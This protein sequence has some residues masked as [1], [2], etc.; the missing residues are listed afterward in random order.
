M[1]IGVDLRQ[2]SVG[3]SGGITQ[4]VQG[5][6]GA[7]FNQYSEHQFLIFCTPFNRSLLTCNA[8]NVRYFSLSIASYFQDLDRIAAE[9]HLQVLFRSYPTEDTL[10]FPMDKQIVLIPDNQHET[11]PD[12]FAAEVLRADEAP[13]QGPSKC[14][15]NRYD[16]RVFTQGLAEFSR[17]PLRRYISDGTVLTGGARTQKGQP[18]DWRIRTGSDS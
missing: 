7:V 4:L 3:A 11:F 9:E 15:G 1:K 16:L 8:E 18:R 17:N 10:Q 14:W 5:V 2:L 13:F 6:F 12:F